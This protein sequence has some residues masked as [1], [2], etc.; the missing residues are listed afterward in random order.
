[1]Y[2]GGDFLKGQ[3]GTGSTNSPGCTAEH[4]PL[5]LH[6]AGDSGGLERQRLGTGPPEAGGRRDDPRSLTPPQEVQPIITPRRQ[7]GVGGLEESHM[8]VGGR[9]RCDPS[10]L[11]PEQTL[12]KHLHVSHELSIP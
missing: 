2:P 7:R 10:S 8:P 6:L 1:M 3:R 12:V 4:D 9:A 11:N 5:G